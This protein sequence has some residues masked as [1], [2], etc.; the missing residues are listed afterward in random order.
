MA[1]CWL[2]KVMLA[3]SRIASLLIQMGFQSASIGTAP[4]LV[5]DM[6]FTK[7]ISWQGIKIR[8]YNRSSGQVRAQV[9]SK[10]PGSIHPVRSQPDAFF[11]VLFFACNHS[12]HCC[13][14]L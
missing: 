3:E 13:L 10:L 4:N 8:T 7:E 14:F 6:V 11:E 9:S 1:T 5:V 12:I 2:A